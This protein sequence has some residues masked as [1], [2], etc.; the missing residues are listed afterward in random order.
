MVAVD[1]PQPW[2]GRGHFFKAV[3]EAIR[4]ILAEKAR[5]KQSRKHDGHMRRVELEM[6]MAAIE[7]PVED[8]LALDE[9]LTR[10]EL[11]WPD[12]AKLVKPKY[13]GCIRN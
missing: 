5:R 7:N 3:A 10:F 11:Q 2:N 6:A 12:R 4:R 8:L 1:Q 13:F 9:A